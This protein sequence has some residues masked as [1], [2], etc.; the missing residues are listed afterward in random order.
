MLDR[1]PVPSAP[2]VFERHPKKTLAAVW[3][4][5]LVLFVAAA[6]AGLKYFAGLGRP[7]LFDA[8]PAY[9]YRLKPN[10]ETWRFGGA[11]FKIN[12]L[13]LRAA[14]DWD[15][16]PE[17]KVLFLGNSVTYGGNHIAN[18]ALFSERAVHDLGV[19]PPL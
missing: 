12:N 4:V 1:M 2:S 5:F 17:G 14:A 13:G 16:S 10:Q 7:V 9:G 3:A 18:E 8:H 15:G 19:V 11:H 6:E